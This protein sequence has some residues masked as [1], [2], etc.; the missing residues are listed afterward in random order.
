MFG[1]QHAPT[2]RQ[3]ALEK[4]L[5]GG[6]LALVSEQAGEVVEDVGS[7]RVVWTENALADGQGAFEQ[8]RG[9]RFAHVSKQRGEVV[10]ALGGVRVLRT[11]ATLAHRQ[12]TLQKGSRQPKLTPG[13]EIQA[14]PIRKPADGRCLR[15]ALR[16]D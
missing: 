13:S 2:D 7:V 11:E 9:G 5:R 6:H 15:D 14:R 8:E 10:E 4:R 3:D 1:T 12:G 16:T